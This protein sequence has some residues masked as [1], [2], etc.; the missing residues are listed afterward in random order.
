[1]NYGKQIIYMTWQA[2]WEIGLLKQL[3]IE[4][5]EGG[6]ISGL[7]SVSD[8]YNYLTQSD[9]SNYSSRTAMYIK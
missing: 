4:L 8:R 6:S 5:V 3:E 9:S 2:I 1:M 7:G